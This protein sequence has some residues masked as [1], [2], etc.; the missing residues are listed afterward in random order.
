MWLT[1]FKELFNIIIKPENIFILIFFIKINLF[2][3]V[4]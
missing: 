1:S 4:S 3:N 2:I